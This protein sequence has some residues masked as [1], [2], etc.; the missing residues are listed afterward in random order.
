[1]VE[2]R[3][4][5]EQTPQ[6]ET[7]E[8]FD[9]ARFVSVLHWVIQQDM[10]L[11]RRELSEYARTGLLIQWP[12]AAPE[13]YRLLTTHPLPAIRLVAALGIDE[14]WEVDQ[15]AAAPLWVQLLQ[16]PDR[17]VQQTTREYFEESQVLPVEERYRLLGQ[18][19]IDEER[20]AQQAQTTEHDT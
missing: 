3:P 19:T 8:D 20:K 14:L 10:E 5:P 13:V 1:M 18:L 2:K 11:V 15:E 17:E 6:D 12:D 4:S 16:D 9:P 7:G